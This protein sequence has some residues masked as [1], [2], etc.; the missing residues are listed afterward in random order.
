MSS[1][2]K[3]TKSTK[4][5]N[6]GHL[7]GHTK[8]KVTVLKNAGYENVFDLCMTDEGMTKEKVKEELLKSPGALFIVGGAMNASY[9]D[10]MTELNEFIAKE[11]PSIIIHN[12]TKADF[13]AG[14][15]MPPSEKI[16]NESALTIASRYLE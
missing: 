9:P 10:L 16:V 3:I 1:V 7:P 13:P 6:I 15:A 4:I 11:I 8:G 14:C 2:G 12:T 5:L